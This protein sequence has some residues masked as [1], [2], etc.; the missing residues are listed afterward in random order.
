MAKCL[1]K[2]SCS[3]C[4][5]CC[6]FLRTRPDLKHET[7]TLHCFTQVERVVI[8]EQRQAALELGYSGRGFNTA[9]IMG[10]QFG[11][12][13]H[14]TTLKPCNARHVRVGPDASQQAAMLRETEKEEQGKLK[15]LM[16]EAAAVRADIERAS[17]L[18]ISLNNQC[19]KIQLDKVQ[20]WGFASDSIALPG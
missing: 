17:G 19:A 4:S 9:D 15:V 6:C 20:G 2:S 3:T 5:I 18:A 12:K 8:L 1:P 14:T 13:N 11:K 16:E 7:H 10:T